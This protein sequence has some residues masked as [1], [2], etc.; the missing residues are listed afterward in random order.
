MSVTY[1][2]VDVFSDRAYTGNPLAV[3][4]GAEGL[5]TEG[6]QA[7]AREFNLSETAFVLPVTEEGADYRVRIF[8]PGAEL[9]FAGHPSVGTAVTLLRRGDVK[10]GKVV[11]ECGA[12]LLELTVADGRATLT[13]ARPSPLAALDAGPLL[14]AAGLAAEDLA[15]EPYRTGSGLEHSF[16][17]VRADAVARAASN[18]R[19]DVPK[20]YLFA[21][22]AEAS[23]A[24]ARLF[25]PGI[26]VAED[27][28]TG[29]AALG[30]G[31]YLV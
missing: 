16:L 27:P 17:P 4:F 25:A 14:S 1:E 2:I 10:A 20:V 31:A 22:D 30:L 18:P 24:H 19:A 12:G 11:Q 28:A 15:G 5:P 21:W 3:V 26:G 9:P 23:R 13:G 29:S 6:L 8:T 7:I